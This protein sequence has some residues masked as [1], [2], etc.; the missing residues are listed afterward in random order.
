MIYA[1]IAF[2][3][4][5][6]IGLPIALVLG[7]VSFTHI[8]TI[9]PEF[10]N[11]IIQRMFGGV[12]QS[13]MVCIPFFV[14][15]G[16]LMNRG[17][18][19][20]KL[21]DLMRE[22]LGYVKGG[23]AYA[24]VAVGV[25]L[26]AILGSANAVSAI[27][28][29][30]AVPELEKDGYDRTF[31][32]SLVAITGVLGPVIPPSVGFVM[33][34]VLCGVSVK[35]LFLAGVIPGIL[36][37]LS[38]CIIIAYYTKKR[39]YPVSV[40]KFHAGRWTKA[41]VKAIP[42]LLVPVIIIGGVLAGVFTPSEAGAVAAV[43][44]IIFGFIYRTMTIKDLIQCFANA[45]IVSSGILLIVAFGN[46]LGWSLAFDRIPTKLTELMLSISDNMYVVMGMILLA[47]LVIGFFLEG[48]AA[49][50]IFAPVFAPLA[51]SV[52]IDLAHFC[53][54]F[55]IMINIGLV[56]PPMGMV[57]F[58]SSNITKAPLEKLCISIWPFVI[59]T[60]V[61]TVVMAF[62]PQVTLFVPKLVGFI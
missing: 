4:A 57:L 26:S 31:G 42:A 58:V 38:I 10:F 33:L 11:T 25:V 52:G 54:I 24:T 29:K 62:L 51:T 41:F 15:A 16:E 30:V 61:C 12:N 49:I 39:G 37:A 13:S 22:T 48:F 18:L 34:G 9:G 20:E 7:I 14:V 45:A 36:L 2:A 35:T 47:L 59:A 46:V 60:F 55:I 53:L 3:V 5:L 40:E 19:T 43:I 32:A 6:V 17:G 27:L 28:C 44:A 8:L 50:L 21:F 1:L 23:L 56:T